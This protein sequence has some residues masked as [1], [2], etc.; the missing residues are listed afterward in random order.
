[1]C[2]CVCVRACVCV[3]VR[4]CVCVS[5]RRAAAVPAPLPAKR[6]F[7]RW[8]NGTTASVA[9]AASS[10]SSPTTPPPPPTAPH[11]TAPSTTA[12]AGLVSLTPPVGSQTTRS[13]PQRA[14]GPD[15]HSAHW[16][17]CSRAAVTSAPRLAHIRAGTDAPTSAPGPTRPHLRRDRRA[18]IYAGTDDPTSAPG[19]R[20]DRRARRARPR[21]RRLAGPTST[22]AS[23]RGW[24]AHAARRTQ[25][26]YSEYSQGVL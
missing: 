8:R 12:A 18:H 24:P 9:S 21:R 10:S 6:S 2:V 19:T 17:R 5:L 23:S 14:P 1:M 26:G 15:P 11:T 20:T 7:V 4:V 16:S 13:E 25:R 3:C 22:R